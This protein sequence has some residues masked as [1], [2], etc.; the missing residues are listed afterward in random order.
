MF[1]NADNKVI[2]D[3]GLEW[4]K[5]D[6]KNFDN[7]DLK[8]I[9]ND[10]FKIFPFKKINKE[11]IGFDMGCGNGRWAKF[12]AP[13]VKKLYC[14]E[15][16]TLA[17]R[18]PRLNLKSY[19]NC[20]FQKASAS[21][22]NLKNNSHDF[23]YSLGVLHHIPDTLS[24]LKNCAKKLKSKAPFLLYLYYNF[25]NKPTWFKIVWKISDILRLII[26]RLPFFLKYPISQIIA[27][28]VYLPV[29][30]TLKFLKKNK[31]QIKNF[32]LSYYHDKKFY[33]MRTDALDRFGTKIE[34]RFSKNEIRKMMEKS[35]FENIT[36]SNKEPYWTVLGTKI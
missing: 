36:F 1:K 26:C 12:I 25:D 2:N 11:S 18:K 23:G 16:S 22:N 5:F 17:I 19:K 29:S 3:F 35:Q 15:P 33:I 32:P 21:K 6:Y 30:I 27:F 34:K 14:I 4:N 28:L 20:I 8:K 13:K 10:Y 24:A 9:F 31:I 7:K